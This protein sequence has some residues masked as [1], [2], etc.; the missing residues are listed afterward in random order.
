MAPIQ[1]FFSPET[2]LPPPPPPSPLLSAQ[3]SFLNKFTYN[4]EFLKVIYFGV[5]LTFVMIGRGARVNTTNMGDDTPLHL[6]AAHGHMEV[7]QIVS[8]LTV[9]IYLFVMGILLVCIQ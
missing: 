2:S 8:S 1:S 3:T 4:K 6:A 9:F 5:F 7:V